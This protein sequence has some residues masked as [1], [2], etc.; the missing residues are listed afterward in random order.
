ML[1][2]EFTQ[3]LPPSPI[4]QYA[5]A[6]F[7]YKFLHPRPSKTAAL[8]ALPA[9]CGSA[10]GEARGPPEPRPLRDRSGHGASPAQPAPSARP[11]P[12]GT[13]WHRAPAPR[14]GCGELSSCGHRGHHRG[15]QR[16]GSPSAA[17]APPQLG[18]GGTPSAP[19][20]PL[21]GRSGEGGGAPAGFGGR[22][23]R[24]A[25]RAGST[26]RRPARPR[27]PH[28]P[29][30]RPCPYPCPCPR[31]AR[32]PSR[33]RS[34]EAGPAAPLPPQRPPVS[35]GGAGG[36][37]RLPRGRG[38]GARCPRCWAPPGPCSVSQPRAAAGGAL[39][40]APAGAQTEPCPPLRAPLNRLG[41]S[42]TSL[43]DLKASK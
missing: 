25:P 21:P 11:C 27:H 10:R 14:R 9:G 35:A 15:H 36:Q 40:Q 4:S 38:R 13:G 5:P 33:P 23:G 12:H 17:A 39:R 20:V 29:Y 7:G 37:R 19:R 18:T 30:L 31:A 42:N 6:I 22:G 28:P 3:E 26:E 43:E 2:P 34:C 16:A 32:R 1:F 41:I 24:C 8:G